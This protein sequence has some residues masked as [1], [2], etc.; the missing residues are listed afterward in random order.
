MVAETRRTAGAGFGRR[1]RYFRTQRGLTQEELAATEGL[2]LSASAINRTEQGKRGV[3]VDDL[4]DLAAALNLAPTTLLYSPADVPSVDLVE[5]LDRTRTGTDVEAWLHGDRPLGD[6]DDVED[7]LRFAPTA[8]VIRHRSAG[9]PAVSAL[10]RL[11]DRARALAA[12]PN[13]RRRQDAE[14]LRDLLDEA[15]LAVE[16]VIRECERSEAEED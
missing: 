4:L 8:A 16:T 14:R 7:W 6:E 2:T 11:L 12:Y 9:H 3:G 1:L 10:D 13:R 15:T 5:V